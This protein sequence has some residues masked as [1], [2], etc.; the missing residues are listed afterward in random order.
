MVRDL[1][2]PELIKLIAS[3]MGQK[4]RLFYAPLSMIKFLALFFASKRN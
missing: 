1:S 2:T 4:A 3:S